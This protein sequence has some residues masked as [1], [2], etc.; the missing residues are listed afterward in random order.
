MLKKTG[1]QNLISA[2]SWQHYVQKPATSLYN[3]CA[4]MVG[5]FLLVSVYS[6]YS[7]SRLIFSVNLKEKHKDEG[8]DT[9]SCVQ[10]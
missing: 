7:L 10:F 5:F 9:Q 3:N 4:L 2:V 1:I 8:S 6:E